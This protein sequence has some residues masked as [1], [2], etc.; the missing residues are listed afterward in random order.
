MNLFNSFSKV[1]ATALFATASIA[2]AQAIQT[3][4]VDVVKVATI[5]KVEILDT[6]E[7]NLAQAMK[8][9]NA[10]FINNTLNNQKLLVSHVKTKRK[11]ST[12]SLKVT[13]IAE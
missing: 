4:T 3:T 8:N 13:L 9:V 7:V 6:V 2:H 1:I 10:T 11:D 5:N 12:E